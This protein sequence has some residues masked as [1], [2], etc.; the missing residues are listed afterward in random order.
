MPVVGSHREDIV[1]GFFSSRPP[2]NR[3]ASVSPPFGS[4]GTHSLAEEGVE[5]GSQ[6]GRWDKHCGTLGIYE[7]CRCR[8]GG[9][10][11]GEVGKEG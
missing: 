8:N 7:F 1:L 11:K 2:P 4:G 10:M 9:R 5:E 3:Q 6:F